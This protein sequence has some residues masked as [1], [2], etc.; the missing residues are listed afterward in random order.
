MARRWLPSASLSGSVS[1]PSGARIPNATVTLTDSEK[2]ITRAFTTNDEGN[3]SFALLPA[4]TYTLTVEA[5]GFKTFKQQ[6]ITLEVGQSGKPDRHSDG[7]D[8]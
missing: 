7:R 6:G 5:A 8:G 4:G 1:D 3:F 2:G